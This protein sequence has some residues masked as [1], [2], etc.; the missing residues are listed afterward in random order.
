MSANSSLEDTYL[1]SLRAKASENT[2]YPRGTVRCMGSPYFQD[3]Y[4]RDFGCLLDVDPHVLSWSCLPFVLTNKGRLH[5]PDF[6]VKRL[7]ADELLDLRSPAGNDADWI[8]AEADSRGYQYRVIGRDETVS[9]VRLANAKDLLRYAR[10][11]T[12]LGDRVRILAGLDENGSLTVTE[13]LGAIHEVPPMAGLASLI[14]HR[15]L[16]VDLDCGPIGPDTHVRRYLGD[17]S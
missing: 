11:H 10:W 14:L 16:Q 6:S 15:F 5:V 7:G 12:P 17:E 8:R 1:H 13:C 3:Q 2:F 4:A 9:D